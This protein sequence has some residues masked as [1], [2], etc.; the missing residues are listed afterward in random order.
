MSTKEKNIIFLVYKIEYKYI[1]KNKGYFLIKTFGLIKKKKVMLANNPP[2]STKRL[3][4]TVF[5]F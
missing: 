1:N 3:K 5:N 4:L 2:K